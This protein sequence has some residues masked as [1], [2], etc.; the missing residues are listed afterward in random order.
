MINETGL[1]ATYTGGKRR[2][3]DSTRCLCNIARRQGENPNINSH[4]AVGMK[5]YCI[6]SI[7]QEQK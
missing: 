5:S 3:F 4:C 7:L 2:T 1:R 6:W